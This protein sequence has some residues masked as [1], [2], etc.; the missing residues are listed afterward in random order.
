[1]R[2]KLDGS[3]DPRGEGGCFCLRVDGSITGGLIGLGG[4]EWLKCGSLRYSVIQLL[5]Y[6]RT[7]VTRAT[8]I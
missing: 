7:T 5:S 3:L 2:E 1:M 8:L 6:P 4:G